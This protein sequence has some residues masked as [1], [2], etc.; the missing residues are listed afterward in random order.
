MLAPW[1]DKILRQGV[2][3]IDITANVTYKALLFLLLL[4]R[5]LD[6]LLIVGICDRW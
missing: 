2:S 4:W 5:R 6:V 3:L 1:T